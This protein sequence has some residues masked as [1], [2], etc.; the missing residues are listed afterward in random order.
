MRIT[1]RTYLKG[2]AGFA[3]AGL[4]GTPGMIRS[5]SAQTAQPNLPSTMIWSTYDVGSTGYVEASAIADAFSRKYGMRVRLQPSG[6]AI[7]RLK[8]LTDGR[9]SHAWLANELFFAMEGLYEYCAPDWG[10]QNLRTLMGRVNSFSVVA[11]KVSG[12]KEPKDLKGKRF[13]IARANSSVNIKV[14]S[15]LAFAGL[16]WDDMEL[17]EFPSYGATLK[18]LV[19]GRAD[20]AGVAPN[21]ATLRELEA[22]Q[23]GIGWVTLDPANKEGWARAQK[24]VP[25]IEPFQ[26]SIG[27]GLSD[28][29]PVWMMGYRYPMITVGADADAD[30]AYAMTKAVAE[31][32]DAYKDANPIMVRWRAAKAGTPPMDAAFHDGAIRYL[33]EA[34]IWKPEYQQWQ[35]ATLKRHATLQAA[36][37]EMMATEA[38]KQVELPELQKLWGEL[39]AEALKSL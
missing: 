36:W 1:R 23:Y 3:A 13:A 20:C 24:A 16:T 39:R 25:F 6:T 30:E 7:G 5:V 4:I 38:A 12:I 19:E 2:T 34:G 21:A 8:P 22:S 14:E 31:S 18:A 27:A 35:D 32:Y 15:I 26:E 28:A 11:T 17:V 10:P 9:V 29:N 33:D 37:K